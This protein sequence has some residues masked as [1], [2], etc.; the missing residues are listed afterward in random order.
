MFSSPSTSCVNRPSLFHLVSYLGH[1]SHREES[2]FGQS[3]LTAGHSFTLLALWNEGSLEEPLVYAELSRGAVNPF[4]IRSSTK[5][6][7]NSFGIRTSKTLDLARIS[8]QMWIDAQERV[9]G[10]CFYCAG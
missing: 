7:S 1:P 9:M 8:H 6:A 10:A 4:R 3:I 5:P 2:A